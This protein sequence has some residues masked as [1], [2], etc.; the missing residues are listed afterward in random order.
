MQYHVPRIFWLFTNY[1]PAGDGL[2]YSYDAGQAEI[3][4]KRNLL[5]DPR[6][7]V[8][9]HVDSVGGYR[10]DIQDKTL[11]YNEWVQ[12]DMGKYHNFLYGG[13]SCF[14]SMRPKCG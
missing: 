13:F 8:V 7:D 10:G 5:F 12:Q 11:Q 3:A 14:T 4:D 1:R 2:K 9:I 6:V